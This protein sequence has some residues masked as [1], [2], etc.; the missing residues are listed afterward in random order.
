METS[1]SEIEPFWLFVSPLNSAGMVYMVTG[2]TAAILY[3]APRLTN[4]L[5]IVLELPRAA[6]TQLPGLFPAAEFY[7]PPPD[8]VEVERTRPS[9]GHFNIIH[10]LTGYKADVYL[11]GSDPLHGW[12]LAHRRAIN[13]ERGSISLAPPE[14][15]I[16]RKLEFYA[17]GGSPKH[18]EDIRAILRNTSGELD[19]AFLQHEISRRGLASVWESA[20]QQL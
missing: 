20:R 4:D 10:S 17:E 6:A 7:L 18:L 3:G 8:V 11:A 9:R 2:A 5:D 14:Y 12:G 19:N 13:L 15:V 16:L 1:H